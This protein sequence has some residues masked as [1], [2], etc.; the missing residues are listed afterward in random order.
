VQRF[1]K[2]KQSAKEREREREKAVK[3]REDRERREV[4]ARRDVIDLL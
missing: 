3:D 1:A 4:V 2:G